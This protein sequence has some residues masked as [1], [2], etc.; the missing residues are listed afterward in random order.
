M[1]RSSR[2]E[3][4]AISNARPLITYEIMRCGD[5]VERLKPRDQ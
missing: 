3:N 1:E 2:K 4:A 5:A